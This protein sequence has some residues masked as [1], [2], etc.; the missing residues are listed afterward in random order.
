MA[1]DV[2]L[3]TGVLQALASQVMNGGDWA[4]AAVYLQQAET[5]K[6]QDPDVYNAATL[7]AAW[8]YW[9]YQQG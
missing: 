5:L 6:T 9:F 1:G 8:G 2:A 7:A 4:E 3:Q